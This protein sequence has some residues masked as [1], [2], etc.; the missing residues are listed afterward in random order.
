MRGILLFLTMAL[1]ATS[2]EFTVAALSRHVI[3][4][5]GVITLAKAGFD[6][7]FIIDRIHTSRTHFDTTVEGLVAL[8]QAGVSEDL[9]GVM[10]A[11]DIKIH[12]YVSP[13]APMGPFS[14]LS[15]GSS[16][17]SSPG[18]STGASAEPAA[19]ARADGNRVVLERHWWGVRWTVVTR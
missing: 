10:A 17:G 13:D 8:K 19:A 5:E 6:E 7:L 14:G 12:P 16:A 11:H 15:T 9:I 3:T 1:P 2:Q 18:S 4:N